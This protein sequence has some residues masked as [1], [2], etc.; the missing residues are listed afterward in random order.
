MQLPTIPVIDLNQ[1]VQGL[2]H[3]DSSPWNNLSCNLSYSIATGSNHVLPL[4][5][6]FCYQYQATG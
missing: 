1:V 4:T 5:R 3:E 6:I 2:D